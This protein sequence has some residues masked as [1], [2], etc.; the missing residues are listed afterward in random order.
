MKLKYIRQ[1]DKCDCGAACLSMISCFYGLYYP[2]QK[3]REI[4]NTS[5]NG[6][7]V[8]NI[9]EGSKKL[10]FNAEALKGSR[11]ELLDAIRKSEITFPFVA[12]LMRGHFVIVSD[13]KKDSFMVLLY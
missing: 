5:K 12:H 8:Y 6:T 4:T 10:G 3:F 13:E 9:V 7:S 11:Q 1:Q 2:L